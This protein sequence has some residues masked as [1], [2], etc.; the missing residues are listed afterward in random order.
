MRALLVSATALSASRALA[1]LHFTEPA[2]VHRSTQTCNRTLPHTFPLIYTHTYTCTTTSKL[3][4]CWAFACCLAAL[5]CFRLAVTQ[6]TL[7]YFQQRKVSLW[8]VSYFH[9]E[10]CTVHSFLSQAEEHLCNTKPDDTFT[11]HR[12]AP[13]WAQTPPSSELN[14]MRHK[15]NNT[16]ALKHNSYSSHCT[17]MLNYRH[18]PACIEW[19]DQLPDWS[20][21]PSF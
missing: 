21:S 3:C 1:S 14:Y 4:Y 18:H 8:A 7:I 10:C 16:I 19:A 17:E 2:H 5:L 15:S 6:W 12:S 11:S 20:I 9:S 13:L